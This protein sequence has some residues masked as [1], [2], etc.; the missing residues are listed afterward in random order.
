MKLTE[1]QEKEL[2]K[3][4]KKFNRD[5][6][7]LKED[8]PSY[9]LPNEVDF[10]E[11][12]EIIQNKRTLKDTIESLNSFKE[13]S[14]LVELPSGAEITKWE[15][16]DLKK[17]QENAVKVLNLRLQDN[18]NNFKNGRMNSTDYN[19]AISSLEEVQRSVEG[20][21]IS[22]ISK[23]RNSLAK[24]GNPDYIDFKT[25]I[26]R[27][28]FWNALKEFSENNPEFDNIRKYLGRIRND[29]KFYEEVQKS[30]AL[31]DF[32][33]WYRLRNYGSFETVEDIAIEIEL[34]L[35]VPDYYDMD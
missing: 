23:L 28:N 20:S 16:E 8:I 17:K 27:D 30:K 5:I 1:E 35:G 22:E 15:L 7:S 10:E 24:I 33:T 32:L 4:V 29:R 18:E 14:E 6:H 26:Y 12:K 11:L 31:Q 25:K 3:A 13:N 34:D 19:G 21:T 9:S 2:K